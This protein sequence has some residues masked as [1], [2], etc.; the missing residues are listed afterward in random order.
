MRMEPDIATSA[1]HGK[2]DI[3]QKASYDWFEFNV[4]IRSENLIGK[5]DPELSLAISAERFRQQTFTA[6]AR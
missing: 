6:H 5:F 4:D 1:Q 2:P 3:S